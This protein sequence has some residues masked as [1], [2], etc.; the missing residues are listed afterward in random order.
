MSSLP[1]FETSKSSLILKMPPASKRPAS[2]RNKGKAKPSATPHDQADAR[3]TI[4]TLLAR[5]SRGDLE[6]LLEESVNDAKPVTYDKVCSLL[7]EKKQALTIQRTVLGDGPAREG[8]GLFDQ[9]DDGLLIGIISLVSCTQ[10]RV[11]CAIAVCKAWRGVLRNSTPPFTKISLNAS[12]F[13]HSHGGS[14]PMASSNFERFITWLPQISAVTSLTLD[15]GNK[16]ASIE[17]NVVKRAIPLFT[18]LTHLS[19]DGRKTTSALLSVVAKQPFC[20]NLISFELGSN[21]APSSDA[22][23]LLSNATRLESLTIDMGYKAGSLL[24]TLAERWREKRGG[25]ASPLLSRLVHE[26]QY[27]DLLPLASFQALAGQFPELTELGKL[28]LRGHDVDSNLD[29]S[30]VRQMSR[31]R[32][33]DIVRLVSQF[34]EGH[35]T[36]DQ[37]SNLLR[38]ICTAAPNLT[39]LAVHHGMKYVSGRERKAGTRTPQLPSPLQALTFLPPSLKFLELGTMRLEPTVFDMTA[40]LSSLEKLT[41]TGCGNDATAIATSLANDNDCCPKLALKN[42]WIDRAC[43]DPLEES[44]RQAEVKAFPDRLGLFL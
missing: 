32:I 4:A 21:A 35:L 29:L 39:S 1:R 14:L 17:P 30:S 36:D 19:L 40:D 16:Y 22:L 42:C 2:S 3:P 15:T 44:K 41:L 18:G 33:L 27:F 8:T 20:F 34:G 12:R 5:C 31:L 9:L 28:R 43:L 38:L 10:T 26:G 13:A 7:P 23:G 25:G 6:K 11:S 37:L 24:S